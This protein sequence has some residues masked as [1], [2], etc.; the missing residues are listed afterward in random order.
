MFL[1]IVL[2]IGLAM[3]IIPLIIFLV[4][5]FIAIFEESPLVAIMLLGLIIVFVGCYFIPV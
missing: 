5:L 4:R 3:F 2:F 1:A